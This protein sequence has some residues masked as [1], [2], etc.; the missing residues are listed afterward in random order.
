MP[1]A[2]LNRQ[3]IICLYP[4]N[5]HMHVSLHASV[6][7]DSVPLTV[8]DVS[9]VGEEDGVVGHHWVTVGQ[10]TSHHVAH[11]VQ[12]AIVYQEVVHE[13]LHTHTHKHTEI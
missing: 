13:Q 10:D 8:C 4:W 7:D 11:A 3:P 12:D 1:R 6:P 2:S 9:V 5:S